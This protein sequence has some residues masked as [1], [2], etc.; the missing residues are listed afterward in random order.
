M[1]GMSATTNGRRAPRVVARV[2]TIMSSIVAGTVE[3]SPSTV[4]AAE[5]PTRI[6]ST[7]AW[8]AI[9]PDG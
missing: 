5:S 1:N 3:S 8:S 9:T 2:R 7:P 4:I 6:R